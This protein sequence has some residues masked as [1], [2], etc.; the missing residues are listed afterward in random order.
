[1]LM[2]QQL[3]F[4]HVG[5]TGGYAD[6]YRWRCVSG[7]LERNMPGWIPLMASLGDTGAHDVIEL[8][9]DPPRDFLDED[10]KYDAVVLYGIYNPPGWDLAEA[11]RCRGMLGVSPK[12]SRRV[13]RRRLAD[14]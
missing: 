13:W 12:H 11:K 8:T 4:A 1:M 7:W 2:K 5:L 6:P 3:R 10:E 9:N 14:S